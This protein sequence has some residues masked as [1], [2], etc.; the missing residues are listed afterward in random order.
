MFA[1]IVGFFWFFVLRFAG[2]ALIDAVYYRVSRMVVYFDLVGFAGCNVGVV[3][4]L[5]MDTVFL[6]FGGL[7]DLV[8]LLY[9]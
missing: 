9:V 5:Y 2:I 8:L 7:D 6:L 4:G 1:G 3:V